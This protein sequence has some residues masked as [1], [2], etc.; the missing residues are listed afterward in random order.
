MLFG[1]HGCGIQINADASQ[2]G[3]G[4]TFGALIQNNIIHDNS[5]G[6]GSGI[7]LDGVQSSRIQGNLLYNNH[8]SGI[9]LFQIDGGS[10]S[11]NNLIVNNTFVMASDARWAVEDQLGK[12]GKH[13]L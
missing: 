13:R 7:N 4:I 6:G 12:H 1:N 10:G 3:T 2:G 8:A 11:L 5:S 9:A